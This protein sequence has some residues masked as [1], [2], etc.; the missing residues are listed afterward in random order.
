MAGNY[1]VMNEKLGKGSFATVYKGKCTMTGQDVAVKVIDMH[2]L[3]SD[4]AKYVKDEVRHLKGLKHPN[5]IELYETQHNDRHML[6]IMELCAGGDLQAAIGRHRTGD[7]RAFT[8]P[9]AQH[10]FRQLMKGVDFLTSQRKMHRDLKSANLLL[11]STDIM[12]AT[13][14][15]ADFG[16]VK[17]VGVHETASGVTVS[18]NDTICGTPLYMAPERCRKGYGFA[19]DIF[20]CGIILFEMLIG[21]VPFQGSSIEAIQAQG[22]KGIKEALPAGHTLS[23][24]VVDLLEQLLRPDPDSRPT[25]REVLAHAW[26][27]SPD[28]AADGALPPLTPPMQAP[29]LP[30]QRLPSSPMIPL[31]PM[32]SPGSDNNNPFSTVL[33]MPSDLVPPPPPIPVSRALYDRWIEF[34]DLVNLIAKEEPSHEKAAALYVYTMMCAVAAAGAYNQLTAFPQQERQRMYSK[35]L[36]IQ[37]RAVS[38]YEQRCNALPQ[39]MDTEVPAAQQLLIEYAVRAGQEGAME[40]SLCNSWSANDKDITALYHYSRAQLVVKG[41]V[42]LDQQLTGADKSSCLTFLTQ[43]QKRCAATDLSKKPIRK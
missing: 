35:V 14:K 17:E 29:L 7:D 3:S 21:R 2:K 6:L 20:S 1:R 32:G 4:K 18:M 19:S 34:G 9:Q 40:E 30:P 13:L 36:D 39:N 27:L 33:D 8:E 11:T 43:I 38:G 24:T 10:L 26:L 23:W 15:I 37:R 22:A 42:D 25:P 41:L 28:G 12:R 5:V 16:L 31:G